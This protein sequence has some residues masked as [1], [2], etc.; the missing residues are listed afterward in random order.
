M[1]KL[2]FLLLLMVAPFYLSAQESET[3]SASQ[4]DENYIEGTVLN[5]STN[6]PLDGVNIINLNTVK[7][8]ISKPDG[9]FR[10]RASSNDTLYFSFLGFKS[11]QI[12]VTNDWKRFGDVKVKM[13]ETGIAL[14]EV[15][16]KDVEL[17][18]YL[19]IDAKNVPVY[20]NVRYSI[21]GLESAY[22]GGNS[23]PG[24]FNKVLSAIFNPAD[25]LNKVFS[26]KG[27]QMRKLRQMK[28]D[29][30][31]RDLLVTKFDR[32][33]LSALLQI[34]REDIETILSRCDYS[35]SFV[36]TANDLQILD[37]LSSCYEEYRVLNRDKG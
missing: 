6:E 5:S 35:E 28:E 23:Q 3:A 30:N 24:A 36:K 7:G 31:I 20:K 2:V 16:V 22:E 1:K 37:A 9:T 29:D 17:T 19:E 32:E 13:T 27:S 21:S 25:F 14:E 26:N 12:R 11:L 34:P 8:T 33:T 15:V 18:G 4:K 10:L